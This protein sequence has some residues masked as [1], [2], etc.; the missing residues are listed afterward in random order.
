MSSMLYFRFEY[1][2]DIEVDREEVTVQQLNQCLV[3][4]SHQLWVLHNI[5]AYCKRAQDSSLGVTDPV[6]VTESLPE[7]S[8]CSVVVQSPLNRLMGCLQGEAHIAYGILP[9]SES[10]RVNREEKS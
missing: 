7:L 8:D 10:I 3:G 1:L 5:R 2:E 6:Y 9:D 4:P